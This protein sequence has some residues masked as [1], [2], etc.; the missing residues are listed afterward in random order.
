[1]MIMKTMN[2]IYTNFAKRFAVVLTLLTF[3]LTSVWAEDE[4]AYTII[5]KNSANGNTQIQ[6]TTK[7]S[8]VIAAN[9]TTFV[10]SQPFSNISKAYYGDNKTSIRIGASSA[11]GTLDIALSNN[12]QVKATKRKQSKVHLLILTT[13]RKMCLKKQKC[14]L[15]SALFVQLFVLSQHFCR[16]QSITL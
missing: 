8:T 5:F 7:S 1:M 10:A 12:G 2:T 6:S 15:L 14:Q 9:C 13:R 4:L 11:P 16:V 3:G